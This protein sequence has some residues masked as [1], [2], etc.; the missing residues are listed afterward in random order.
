MKKWSVLPVL[1]ML[2]LPLATA[3]ADTVLNDVSKSTTNPPDVTAGGW[4]PVEY[5]IVTT[6]NDKICNASVDAP[7][8]LM[9]NVPADTDIAASPDSPSFTDCGQDNAEEVQFHA[10]TP[11]I[12]SIPAVT[13]TGGSGGYNTT[14]TPFT[15]WV[16]APP[17]ISSDVTG[18]E[19]NNGW[20]TS[21][22]LAQWSMK[23]RT[24]TAST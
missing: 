8:T 4:I 3:L 20:Y 1:V 10:S 5:W 17:V 2:V 6:G 23:I 21:D 12:Y 16:K 19:G 15:L 11:G 18:T 22:V 24:V 7:T 13:A 9:I 14:S